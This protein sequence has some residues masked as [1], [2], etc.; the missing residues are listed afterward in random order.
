[1][2]DDHKV[3]ILV[4]DDDKTVLRSIRTSLEA[5]GF[6][7]I[8][9][10]DGRKG[11]ELFAKERP[12]L[13][14]VDLLMEKMS[15]IEVISAM[16]EVSPDIP[17]VVVSGTGMISDVIESVRQGAWDYVVKP[18]EDDGILLH[19]I[20]NSLDKARLIRENRE[21]QENI[22]V[23]TAELE[24]LFDTI[25]AQVWYLKDAET[26]G[27][28]NKVYAN[29]LGYD[30]QDLQNS[31]L[32]DRIPRIDVLSCIEDNKKVF[33]SGKQQI[34][35]KWVTRN[36]DEKRLFVITKTPK[37]DTFG[38][39]EFVACSG[40][41]ITER[42][43][44]EEALKK[45]K[46]TAEAAN[47]AK[48]AFLANMSHEIRTP[49]NGVMGMAGLL[50]GTKLSQEQLEYAETVMKSAESLL[51]VIND[52]L[53]FSKVESG[54][55]ELEV[56]DFDLR[57][58][59]EDTIDLL[60]LRAHEKNL[61]FVCLIETEV[62]SLLKGDPG[63][64]R[65]IVIN[66]VGNAI[67]FTLKG[68]VSVR[69]G[70]DSEDDNCATINIEVIDTGIGIPVDKQI[71]L[72]DSFM[73]ADSS[74]TRM[75]GG[76]GLGLS[77]SKLI[78]EIMGGKISLKS[79]VERGS[80]FTFSVPFQKQSL[81]RHPVVEPEQSIANERILVVDDNATSR[82]WFKVLLDEWN[83]RHMGVKDSDT[84]LK[85][86]KK[87]VEQDD[88][89]RV[90]IVDT[91]MPDMKG[92]ALGEAIKKDPNLESTLL[93]M[94]AT[95]GERGDAERLQKIGYSAYLSKPIKQS[96]LFEC[97]VTILGEKSLDHGK[98]AKRIVTRH[99][100]NEKRRQ[101]V[102][103]L[104]AEDNIVNQK[105]A[106][107]VLEKLGYN[108]DVA[109]NGVKV[110]KAVE[111]NPYDLILMDCQMPEMDGWEATKKIRQAELKK[112]ISVD[113]QNAFQPVTIIA[114]T[115]HAM[116]GDRE[117][118]IDAGMNDYISKPIKP[119]I[120]SEVIDKWLVKPDKI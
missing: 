57:V 103:I 8:E 64:L 54:K 78:A 82:Q 23:R 47:E 33:A 104:L 71:A 18:I 36:D 100:I 90:A 70:L 11:L 13:V 21:Y 81:D 105:L 89:F 4:I 40:I 115:A 50:L 101:K 73:Q 68:E 42:K 62:P 1:M 87:A 117:K 108:A 20:Q 72:F 76:T 52:I 69:I 67:K 44:V 58:A 55:M 7:V 79:E 24:T 16:K 15:G 75:F 30:K 26:Y 45:A 97:L 35:E 94:M 63:R 28:V 34:T 2:K 65:Q 27:A 88:P 74:T 29:F 66:L 106:L 3:S 5:N 116:A 25:G 119:K 95:L 86:L 56:I 109:V 12:N 91:H 111:S 38:D 46:I 85:E 19:A 53:D 92:E 14:L 43:M 48:S 96:L 114:M 120:L 37:L 51:G 49:M 80:T 110:V 77:I 112:T 41:D 93:L 102:R 99:S 31:K 60:A 83:C 22:V 17:I 107:K 9:A 98:T 10:E 32:I 61:E 113:K 39:V 118:C 59:M 84:A 6:Y